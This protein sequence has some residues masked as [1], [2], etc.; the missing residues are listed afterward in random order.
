MGMNNRTQLVTGR[1]LCEEVTY[2]I[3][4]AALG[5]GFCH[6][7]ICQK[8]SGGPVNAWTAFPVDAVR[9]VN[10][11]PRFYQSSRIAER[12][13]CATCGVSITYRLLRPEPSGY[14][15]IHTMSLDNPE[16]Y[17]PTWHGGVESQ[18][19]WNVMVDDLPR[20]FCEES[21]ELREAWGS[22]G[23]FDPRLW[24]SSS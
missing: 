5:G 13:F 6:C 15:A 7:R 22:A 10:K 20:K 3:N 12:G 8:F 1:C 23:I 24:N 11:A 21:K 16:R 17:A 4:Q 2:E 18:M 19:P 14:L 9:F